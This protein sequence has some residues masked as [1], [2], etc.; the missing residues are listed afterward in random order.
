METSI[1]LT[2]HC[3]ERLEKNPDARFNHEQVKTTRKK[4]Q[5]SKTEQRDKKCRV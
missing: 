1:P 4:Q 5:K 3:Q 2:D